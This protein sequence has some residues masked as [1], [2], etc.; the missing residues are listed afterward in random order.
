MGS[1]ISFPIKETEPSY[2]DHS[3]C[4]YTGELKT[5]STGPVGPKNTFEEVTESFFSEQLTRRT[6]ILAARLKIKAM[7]M[8]A[9]LNLFPEW[10][11]EYVMDLKAQFQT[12]DLNND[13]LIDFKELQ[14]VLDE[15]GDT[16]DEETRRRTFQ[17]MDNDESGAIDFEE[18][19]A[20]I[21]MVT[22]A[23]SEDEINKR[24]T[25]RVGAGAIVGGEER[26]ENASKLRKLSIVQQI[27]HGLF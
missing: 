5:E 15:I 2:V 3:Q 17:E 9:I 10:N 4:A 16:T 13:G 12:F 26:S 8:N 18:Y 1:F 20:L 19:L 22:S 11:T 24:D 23:T 25:L 27:T 14:V 21:H 6:E 7:D